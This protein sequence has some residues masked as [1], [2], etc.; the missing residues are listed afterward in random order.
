MTVSIPQ[1]N[2]FTQLTSLPENWQRKRLRYLSTKPIKNGLGEAA[3]HYNPNHP[4]YIRITDIAGPRH[5]HSE[6]FCSLPPE[7]AS[8]ALL[9]KDDILISA[10]GATYGKSFYAKELN[11][12]TC[13]AGYLVR[14]SAI[15]EVNPSFLAYWTESRDYWAQV[16]ANVIQAT[17]QNFSASKVRHLSAPFPPLD[18]QQQIARFLDDKTARIDGLIEKKRELLE[19]LAEKRQALIT[20]AVTRGID[21]D[22]PMKPSGISLASDSSAN[23]TEKIRELKT[24]E[25]KTHIIYGNMPEAWTRRRLRFDACVNPKKSS[26][27]MASNELVSFIPMKAISEYGCLNL[28]DV[29]E[30]WDVYDNY[31]YFADGDVCVAKITPCFENGKGALAKGLISG[32][33]FGTTELHILRPGPS[34][35]GHFLFYISLADDFRKLGE[36]EMYGAGG[37]KRV[38][39]SFIKDWM[40]PIPPLNVQ[41]QIARFL[42]KKT[43]Q[44]DQTVEKVEDSI[45]Q[46]EEYRSALI[47]AAVTGQLPELK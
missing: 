26:L 3:D 8:E 29:R 42:D 20:H 45:T 13:F 43:T 6:T 28:D 41:K 2:V 7:I 38:D 1:T 22:T 25:H 12:D 5:L 18:T 47:T 24:I 11:E 21:P 14:L 9:D 36:S 27:N 19:C 37:Q 35:Y 46:M 31:T 4:R 34:I 23:Q 32:V 17:I 16:D 44:I 10:V 33:G 40:T 30:L 15:P 39:E